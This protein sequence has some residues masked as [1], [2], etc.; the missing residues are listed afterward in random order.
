MRNLITLLM[1]LFV[2]F[3][4]FAAEPQNMKNGQT[5]RAD[6]DLLSGESVRL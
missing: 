5:D 3:A 6:Q 2:V 4:T 1:S